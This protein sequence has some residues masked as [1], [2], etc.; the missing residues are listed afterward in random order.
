MRI[1]GSFNSLETLLSNYPST[2]LQPI[3]TRTF[4]SFS[5]LDKFSLNYWQ[6]WF[7]DR[8]NLDCQTKEYINGT[9]MYY[10]W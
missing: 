3:P 7:T 9:E 8:Q 2:F 10:F 1:Y 6:C 4:P 5:P